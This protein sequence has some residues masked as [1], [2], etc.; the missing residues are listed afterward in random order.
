MSKQRNLILVFAVLLT[1]A[2]GLLHGYMTQRWGADERMQTAAARLAEIPQGIG[3]W[4]LRETKDLSK[5]AIDMLQCAGYL[6]NTYQNS[7]TQQ[8]IHVTLLVGPGA[9]MAIHRPEICFESSNYSILGA[10]RKVETVDKNNKHHELWAIDFETN[11]IGKKKLRVLYG[12][13]NSGEWAAPDRPRLAFA[14][15]R[16]LYKIQITD[17]DPDLGQDDA[18]LQ[19]ANVLFP[20]L[21]KHIMTSAL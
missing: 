13:S 10:K 14:G 5:S 12:W 16:V 2:S 6:N 7:K 9:T 3:D 21:Q 15:E 11:D 1:V 17:A 20:M 8:R 19:F 18:S 4:Q